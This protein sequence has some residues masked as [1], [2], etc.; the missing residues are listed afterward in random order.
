MAGRERTGVLPY[1]SSCSCRPAALVETRSGSTW[2][3][4]PAHLSRFLTGVS[5]C[6]TNQSRDRLYSQAIRLI[7]RSYCL[8]KSLSHFFNQFTSH[9]K[10][11]K[12]NS[13]L[14][15]VATC[16]FVFVFLQEAS[17]SRRSTGARAL[18][19]RSTRASAASRATAATRCSSFAAPTS[20]SNTHSSSSTSASL[21][22]AF[23]SSCSCS[24]CFLHAALSF[25]LAFLSPQ[26]ALFYSL[27]LSLSCTFSTGRLT[28]ML[29]E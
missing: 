11:I 9:T 27:S 28:G 8:D 17:R 13:F 1:R 24:C 15:L 18:T 26:L 4:R 20:K 23:F 10:C 6:Q 7:R 12:I 14:I 2:S 19:S 21:E 25:R 3:T 22:Y 29:W 5:M 16:F